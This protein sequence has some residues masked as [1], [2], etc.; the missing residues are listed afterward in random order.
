MTE[1]AGVL[2]LIRTRRSVGKFRPDPVPRAILEQALDAAVWV[3]NHRLTEPWRFFV[4][5]GGAK[6]RFAAIRRDFRRTLMP[7]PDAPEVQAALERVYRDA[8]DTPV[9]V[10]V[11]SHLADD[12]EVREEDLWATFGAAY[13]FMLALWSFG[14]GTYFRTGGLRDHPPLRE[15]LG[16]G[17]DRRIVGVVYAGYPLEVPQR[18]RTPAAQKTVWMD[19]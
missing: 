15:F 1:A 13:A 10:V 7:N 12:P 5:S 17:A 9:I 16:L 18:R 19:D 8:A 6:E 3:P 2:E 4:L 14:V 11:T